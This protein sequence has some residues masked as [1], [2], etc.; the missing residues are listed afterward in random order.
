MELELLILFTSKHQTTNSVD[1]FVLGL[2]RVVETIRG[3][4]SLLL[5]VLIGR[6]YRARSKMKRYSERKMGLR[7]ILGNGL[8]SNASF[9]KVFIKL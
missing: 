1:I 3:S 7:A 2:S 8:G 4:E 6:Q 9:Y 5:H